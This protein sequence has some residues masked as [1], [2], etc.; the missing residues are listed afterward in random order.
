MPEKRIFVPLLFLSLLSTTISFAAESI[1]APETVGARDPDHIVLPVSH[2]TMVFSPLV[3][4]Q[5]A[6]FL[7]EGKFDHQDLN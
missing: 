7:K 6:K 1:A 5:V 4:R 2:T 3:T